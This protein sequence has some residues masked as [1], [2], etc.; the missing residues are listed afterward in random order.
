MAA[1][2]EHARA[3]AHQ[4]GGRK[5]HR[6]PTAL[7][8]AGAS[9]AVSLGVV[10]YLVARTGAPAARVTPPAPGEAFV[11]TT[12][13]ERAAESFLEAWRRGDHAA[14]LRMARGEAARTVR[15]RR[16]RDGANRE[17]RASVAE[18]RRA[19]A[20]AHLELVIDQSD[21]P[22]PG[23][24][25]IRGV[26]EGDLDGHAFERPVGMTL[27]RADSTDGGAPR[28]VVEQVH[29][30]SLTGDVPAALRAAAPLPR[31]TETAP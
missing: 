13:P 23:H 11:D 31:P 26:A 1:D 16:D 24:V 27:A 28:W 10:A 3:A 22:R 12:T 20:R 6:A 29:L 5:R 18:A 17:A 2:G 19:W 15:A 7:V 9:T 25:V 14:C 8:L 21:M 30:G 4:G